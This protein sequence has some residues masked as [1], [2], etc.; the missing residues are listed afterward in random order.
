MKNVLD[1]AYTKEI[2]A[3]LCAVIAKHKFD[4]K[5]HLPAEIV[6]ALML[7][8]V[9]DSVFVINILN[10]ILNGADM[11]VKSENGLH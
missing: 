1:D 10:D 2:F 9:S 7:M 3:D 6:A 4:D 11:A 8:H 5:C